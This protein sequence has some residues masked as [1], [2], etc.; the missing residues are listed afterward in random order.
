MSLRSAMTHFLAS[1][2]G[3]QCA[4]RLQKTLHRLGLEIRG[5]DEADV[6]LSSAGIYEKVRPYTMTSRERIAAVVAATEYLVANDVAGAIVEC[7]V[8]RGGSAMAALYALVAANQNDRD[9]YLYDTFAG[10]SEP[11]VNDGREEHELFA[12]YKNA[13]GLSDW[14]LATLEDVK[15][16]VARCNYPLAKMNFVPGKVEET[17]PARMPEK[18]ALLRLDTDW[19]ESTLHELNHLYPRLAEGGILIIDDYG[20]WGGCRQAVDEYFEKHGPRPFLNR[21]DPAGRLIVKPVTST[22]TA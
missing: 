8:W 17:I 11:G 7:G 16:N 10:M 21:V 19:Y 6:A 2:L 9:I 12:R 1:P 3:T 20:K 15:E 18:I 14:C 5:V 22:Q 4:I 13:Q